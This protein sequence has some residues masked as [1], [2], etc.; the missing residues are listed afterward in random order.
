MEHAIQ[1]KRPVKAQIPEE[2]IISDPEFVLIKRAKLCC[3]LNCQ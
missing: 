3:L 1:D 2:T